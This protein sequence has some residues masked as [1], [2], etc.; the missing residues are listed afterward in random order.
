MRR[1][2]L[3]ETK[4]KINEVKLL[5]DTELKKANTLVL[6]ANYEVAKLDFISFFKT[7]QTIDQF[8]EDNTAEIGKCKAK[9][10]KRDKT[11][12]QLCKKACDD[13]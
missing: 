1:T 8:R 11:V 3:E 7:D 12:Q 13:S 5:F 6:R 4:E 2:N 10:E 9:L